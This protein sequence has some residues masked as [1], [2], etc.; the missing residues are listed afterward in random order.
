MQKKNY[1]SLHRGPLHRGPLEYLTEYQ[2]V[3]TNGGETS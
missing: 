3:H 1:K 2:P